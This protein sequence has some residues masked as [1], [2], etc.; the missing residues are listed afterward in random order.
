MSKGR[1]GLLI[2]VFALSITLANKYK[3]GQPKVATYTI[4]E[5]VNYGNKFFDW[6]YN[7]K[8]D[9]RKH[10]IIKII[11]EEDGSGCTAFVISDTAAL[12]AGHCIS[13]TKNYI[14]YK[15]PELME[16]SKELEEKMLDY[17][18]NLENSCNPNDILCM[19][20]IRLTETKLDIE[21]K[22][23]EIMLSKKPNTFEV[24]DVNGFKTGIKV[25]A[26]SRDKK[27]DYGFLEGNFKD[28]KKFSFRDSWYVKP[29]D[30]LKIC[31]FY[32]GRLPPTC[33]DFKAIGNHTLAYAGE[34]FIVPGASGSPVIDHTDS[35]V[36]VAV[37]AGEDFVIIEPTLG[38]IDLLSDE[39]IKKIKE[40]NKDK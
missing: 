40:H 32:G 4:K 31:G 15:I 33:V 22:A 25:I 1:F 29:G 20:E 36:A 23:R 35:V 5:R 8:E 19:R 14:E 3:E 37:A 24:I 7:V 2:V 26:F 13:M 38:M 16:K 28:F 27:R 6:L 34:G 17:I 30:I 18:A 39:E 12:T 11:D 21:L 10:A 9:K